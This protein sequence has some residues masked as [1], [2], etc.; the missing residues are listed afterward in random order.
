MLYS[1]FNVILLSQ[2]KSTQKLLHIV[3]YDE[4]DPGYCKT[5]NLTLLRNY[6]P[7]GQ[8]QSID[9][10]LDPECLGVYNRQNSL[11][12][13]W[14]RKAGPY[15]VCEHVVYCPFT[16]PHNHYFKKASRTTDD[17]G[18]PLSGLACPFNDGGLATIWSANYDGYFSDVTLRYQTWV[19]R[20]KNL[21]LDC[22]P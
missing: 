5:N 10:I 19:W 22:R 4:F 11:S 1:F 20:Q 12:G 21:L 17:P 16:C 2:T 6:H 9:L 8:W 18:T 13:I 7:P 3:G 15:Q 14:L